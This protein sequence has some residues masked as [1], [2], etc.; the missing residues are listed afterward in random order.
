[1]MAQTGNRPPVWGPGAVS[2][3]DNAL[4]AAFVDTT[5]NSTSAKNCKSVPLTV[6]VPALLD[7][8]HDRV[9]SNSEVSGSPKLS[10][11]CAKKRTLSSMAVEVRSQ[12]RLLKNY[13]QV[14]LAQQ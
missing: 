1:M 13:F 5:T 6:P 9:G 7:R 14:R 12:P 2:Y 3:I 10:P 4:E 8:Q 11:L